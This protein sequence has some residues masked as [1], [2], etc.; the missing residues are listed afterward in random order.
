M[1]KRDSLISLKNFSEPEFKKEFLNNSSLEK[2]FLDIC[3][4]HID[5]AL[6]IVNEN[7]YKAL[8]IYMDLND[9]HDI[10]GSMPHDIIDLSVEIVVRISKDNVQKAISLID[11]IDVDDFKVDALNEIIDKT[12]NESVVKI[13]NYKKQTYENLIKRGEI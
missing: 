4:T 9:F 13:L 6:S 1:N 7:P 5:Y 3:Q 12:N 8:E 10:L 2:I 11:I